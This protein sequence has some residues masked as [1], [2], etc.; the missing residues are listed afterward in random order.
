MG[1]T[2]TYL[3]TGSNRVVIAGVRNPSDSSSKSLESLPTGPGSKVIVVFI[4]SNDDA[5]AKKAI[6]VLQSQHNIN[7]IDTVNVVGTVALF[8]AVWPLLKASPH[9]MPMALSTG[10]ASIGDMKSLPL[11][12]TAWAIS[13][14]MEEAL[15]NLDHATRE[16]ISGTFQ[17]FYETQYNW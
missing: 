5:S 6:D 16:S 3:I 13:V 2:K 11:P 4:D 15:V 8:Q 17:S 7:K 12:A 9:L 1:F 14:G 10:V